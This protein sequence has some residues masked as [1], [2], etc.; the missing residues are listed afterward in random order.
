M[1][2]CPLSGHNVIRKRS[3]P[4]PEPPRGRGTIGAE[5][6]AVGLLRDAGISGW[7]ADVEVCGHLLDVVSDAPR[8]AVETVGF[9]C[10]RDVATFRRDR[11]KRDA[12]IGRGTVLDFTWAD[13]TEHRP[14][15]SNRSRALYD[16]WPAEKSMT[17][18]PETG[19]NV[20]QIQRVTASAAS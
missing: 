9:A 20:I 17:L 12:P 10:H 14:S 8:P 1:T 16:G 3:S 13:L 15:S 5:R 6:L 4:E 11:T 18:C 19:H 2:L 7:A